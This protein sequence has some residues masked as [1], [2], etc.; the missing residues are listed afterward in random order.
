MPRLL[1]ALREHRHV[2][3]VVILLTLA[4]TF[5]TI[6]YVFKT[7]VF[8]HPAGTSLDVYIKM[9][10]DWYGNQVLMGQ[11]DRYYTDLMFFPEG[12]SLASH[13]LF[14]PHSIVVNALQILLPFS[15]AFSLTYLLII[16]LC[17]FS[18]YAYLEW[19]FIDKWI[20]LLGAVVVG[21][22]PH[23]VG[24]PNHPDSAFIATI[25]AAI[26]CIHRGIYENRRVLVALAGLLTGI[27]T[28]VI[29]YVYVCLLFTLGFYV[30]ALAIARWRDKRFW[31]NVMLLM[32]IIALSS[33]WRVYPLV[34]NS[35][36]LAS[37]ANWHG[38]E[39]I[40]TDAISYFVNHNNPFL[41]RLFS[42]ISSDVARNKLSSNSYLGYLPL[43][44]ISVGMLT[45]FTRRKMA[46]WVFLCALF[47]ILRLGSYLVVNGAAFD[48]ILLPKYYLNQLL[49][50]VFNSFWEADHFMMGA[51]L[52]FSVLVCYGLIALQK[53][54]PLAARPGFVL[55]LII[56]VGFEY[57]IP[58]ETERIFPEGDGAISNERLAF[59]D[60]LDKE[61]DDVRLINLP[62][63]RRNSKIYNLY[64]ALS[65]FP[66][67]EGA[68]SRTPESA[69][70]YIRA[71]LLLNNWYEKLPISCESVDRD[72]YLTGLAQ[73]E[74]DG[75]SHVVYHLGFKYAEAI[76]DSFREAEP[77]Y[78]DEYVWIFNL[79]DF[80]DSCTNELS[81]RFGFTDAYAGTLQEHLIFD[82]RRG[83]V[84]VFPPTM[85]ANDHFMR[86][87]RHFSQLNQDVITITTDEYANVAIQRLTLS[88]TDSIIDMG[89]FAAL[90]L[91]NRPREFN[92]EQTPAFQDW[93]T[94]RFHYC[95]RFFED[96]GTTIDAYLRVD[97]PCSA[98][99]ESSEMEVHYDVELRLHNIS[100]VADRALL[101]FFLAW[102][103]TSTDNY[104][105]SLQ[106]FDDAGQKALQ[107]DKVI[108]RQL[109]EVHEI[110]TSSLPEG[111][112]S[113][114][115]IVYDFE[116]QVNQGG[117][118]SDS[119]QSFSREFEIARIEAR[120]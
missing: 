67:A 4:T 107:D 2:F 115:L 59:L 120:P 111:T 113:I 44:L 20:A 25:P 118:F 90:W 117:T 74:E 17:A 27:T 12:L 14:L 105:Y 5:P 87:L 80:R 88:D 24:H 13:P 81:V 89:Q 114:Q 47:L 106:F 31:L 116:T 36:S 78:A 71:N 1:N 108:S 9:W 76:K 91:V 70:D 65:G 60:W 18:A 63:G 56:I 61:D 22:S 55:A 8:W 28:V 39:E 33:Y 109:L 75:F 16:A 48:Y 62:M 110:D 97:I 53:R 58:V 29:L 100:Y 26:Y 82:E 112:Y 3:I 10:D 104:A 37:A 7:D 64:Q 52:P 23:V 69:F 49:P 11:A 15:N 102:T 45:T 46:P 42:S 83:T 79:K 6:V 35:E 99:D 73:L 72:V 85:Q 103:N 92:A 96:E 94:A 68:I 43:L 19:L 86:Y 84:V 77:S 50:A 93:F 54:F 40:H 95:Q 41:D 51:L 38:H 98:M 34:A 21:F 66:H 30:F 32:A 57:H 119:G 101:R